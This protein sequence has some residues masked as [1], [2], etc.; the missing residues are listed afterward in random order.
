[1]IKFK[2]YFIK[3]FENFSKKEICEFIKDLVECL[4]ELYVLLIVE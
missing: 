1:M 4:G 2:D 3:F